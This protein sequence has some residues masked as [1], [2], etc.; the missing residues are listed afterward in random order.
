MSKLIYGVGTNSKGRYKT[1]G[2]MTN[3]YRAWYNMLQ[4]VYCPKYHARQPTYLGCSVTDE[5][6]EYQDFAEW[7]ESHDYSDYSDCGYQLDKDLLLP[8]NKVYAPDRCVFV[9]RQLNSLLNDHSNARGQYKQGVGFDKSRNKFAA[10][11]KINGKL[12]Q[13][14]R[15]DTEIEAYS[16]Y[17]KAKEAYV[18]EKALEWRDRIAPNVFDALMNWK[19]S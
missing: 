18:K 19:L 2:K 14:G 15:F 17:K 6:L 1:D 4:R 12:K 8:N 16:A 5:W 9:P 11:I 7:F 3:A 10:H 13:L